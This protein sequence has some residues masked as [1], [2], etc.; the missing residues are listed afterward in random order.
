MTGQ[1]DGAERA[2]LDSLTDVSR[3]TGEALAHY[4]ALLLHWTRRINLIAPDTVPEIWTRHVLDSAQLLP[5]VP[6]DARHWLDIGS[7]GGLPGVVCALLLRQ[8]Q[9]DLRFTLVES[10]RRKAAFLA[11]VLRELDI[12]ATLHIARIEALPPQAADVISARAF[13]P[14]DRLLGCAVPHLAPGGRLLLHKGARAE[15]E[16]DAA[17]ASWRFTLATRPSITSR[18]SRILCCEEVARV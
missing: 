6:P 12:P 14:L 4:V 9:P 2:A 11:T 15:A 10:D 1:P 7:G 13:A 16:I 8:R 17:R 5:L 3:E 18:M